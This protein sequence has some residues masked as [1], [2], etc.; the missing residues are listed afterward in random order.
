MA[1]LNKLTDFKR[2]LIDELDKNCR[3]SNA[4]IAKR[5][6]VGKNVVNYRLNSL[7]KE[8]IIT[9]FYSVVDI[10]KLGYFGI[11]LYLKLRFATKKKEQE[12]LNSLVK[13]NVTWWV[14]SIDGDYDIGIVVR[15]KEINDFYNFWDH[16]S[17][18]YHRYMGKSTIHVH[19]ATHEYSSS[20][21]S[22]E[23][24]K[25]SYAGFV[26]H[27]QL[28]KKEKLVL[29]TLAEQS[30][31]PIVEI[32]QKTGISTI[33]VKNII[34]R[35]VKRGIIKAFKLKLNYDK[36]GLTLY[37]INFSLNDF[38]KKAEMLSY[39]NNHS[40]VLF[41]DESIG[42]AD[43]EGSF[44]VENYARFKEILNNYIS[45][46]SYSIAD[47]NYFVYSKIHKI[48]YFED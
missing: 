16:F 12:I 42:F 33:A 22:V 37:K 39:T 32:A 31:M 26:E 2:R 19:K 35:L 46:C 7:I 4:Q 40:N 8:Q 21:F 41:V 24:R 5:L 48:K 28:S 9:G 34:S 15:V 1:E 13:S 47:V 18:L 38:S 14:G 25:I 36:L 27:A 11:R 17:K 20:F 6:K 29:S 45:K 43:F 30:R 10:A 23:G 3:Q 44:L